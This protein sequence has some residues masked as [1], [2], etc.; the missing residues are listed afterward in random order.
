[1]EVRRGISIVIICISVSFAVLSFLW[2]S[3]IKTQEMD[4]LIKQFS[5]W[6]LQHS[7]K[8]RNES[9]F[10]VSNQTDSQ[11]VIKTRDTAN[12]EYERRLA[13]VKEHC[14]KQNYN[15]TRKTKRLVVVEKHKLL[16]CTIGKSGITT[17][18]SVILMLLGVDPSRFEGKV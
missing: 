10:Q 15:N 6:T 9:S 2:I 5:P 12:L 1:M 17:F 11:P 16:Y 8:E 14:L 18:I 3:N 7:S 4:M 13:R